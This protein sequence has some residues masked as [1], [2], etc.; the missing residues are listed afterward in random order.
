MFD[1]IIVGKGPAGVSAALY[2][3]RAGFEPVIIA[4]DY[5]TLSRAHE[6][7]N[8]YGFEEPLTGLQ[9]AQKGEKQAKNLG[10]P[11]MDDEVLGISYDDG[12]VV[13]G[14]ESKIKGKALILATGASRNK[15]K[16]DGLNALEGRGVSYCAIC[17]GFFYRGKH[18]AVLG[19]G[20]YALHEAKV[21]SDIAAKV[22]ILTNGTPQTAD[23]PETYEIIREPLKSIDGNEVITGVTFQDG[24]SMD[25][26]GLFVA[27]GVAG[28]ADFAK[29]LGAQTKGNTI[30]V[31]EQC[32]TDLPG[33]YAAGDCTGGLLQVAKAVYQGMVAGM[34]SVKFVR[35]QK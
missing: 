13:E 35:E 12:Y 6:I 28:S 1:V 31:N 14:R 26:D 4:K 9:L 25:L 3:K 24:N 15:A 19:S 22:T 10:I 29:K 7:P 16:I 18:I 32:E 34:Q 23:F 2:V 17:D 33:L 27:I 5:G 30:V 21:L 11:I 20:E 8:Y